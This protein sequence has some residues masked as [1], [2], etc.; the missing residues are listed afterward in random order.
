MFEE[1]IEEYNLVI[2]HVSDNSLYNL[3]NRIFPTDK[4][5]SQ[6]TKEYRREREPATIMVLSYMTSDLKE[7]VNLI[8]H[9]KN[10]IPMIGAEFTRNGAKFT[11]DFMSLA[12]YFLQPSKQIED[13]FFGLI[14]EIIEKKRIK[15][16]NVSK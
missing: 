15:E 11:R 10:N 7:Y 12:T 9:A 14:K 3:L 13:D 1:K 6:F 2:N 16:G 5:V 4:V 8:V